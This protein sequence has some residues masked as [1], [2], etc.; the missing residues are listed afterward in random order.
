MRDGDT[1]S[2]PA[3]VVVQSF[4]ANPPDWIG[5]CME[6]VRAW[7]QQA[8]FAYRFVGDEL[9]DTLPDWVR[10]KTVGRPQVASDLARLNVLADLLDEGWESAVWLDADVLVF[11]PEG[12]SAALDL[13]DGYLLGREAWVQTDA[14]GRLRAPRGIHN[15][16]C[17][18]RRGNPFLA[19]YRDAATRILARHNGP[20]VPQ[21]IGPKFLKSLDNMLGL[22][23]TWAVNMASPRLLSD[24]AGGRGP[25]LRLFNARSGNSPS[26]LNLCLSYTGREVDD[27][28]V[29]TNLIDVAID[30]LLADFNRTFPC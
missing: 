13:S 11:D 6:S 3:T 14:K 4:H 28:A 27:I 21:L 26:A 12:L 18:M 29:D 25:A 19:F 20:M 1:D 15:A 30:R 22:P 9:F 16:L 5:Q 10:A 24:I 17:A 8:G 23:A 7:S 2:Y